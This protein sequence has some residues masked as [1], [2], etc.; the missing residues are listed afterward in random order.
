MIEINS[1]HRDIPSFQQCEKNI[2]SEKNWIERNF[3]LGD[4]SNAG[5]RLAQNT[6]NAV[7]L[8]YSATRLRKLNS[9][10]FS[11]EQ[12]KFFEIIALRT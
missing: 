4:V 8:A 7:S 6:E 12:T 10:P 9:S 11:V 5:M 1:H 3:G 2:F